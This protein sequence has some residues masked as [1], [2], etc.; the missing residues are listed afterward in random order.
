[1]FIWGEK[2]GLT[3]AQ[4][5]SGPQ[6]KP[7]NFIPLIYDDSTPK[8]I[9]DGDLYKR[10]LKF[11]LTNS[12]DSTSELKL[13]LY[14]ICTVK[15]KQRTLWTRNKILNPYYKDITVD[16]I[17]ENWRSG[18]GTEE[19]CA[20][21]SGSKIGDLKQKVLDGKVCKY[22]NFHCILTLNGNKTIL[23]I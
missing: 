10:Q 23:L 1:M 11:T 22:L 4:S 14:E 7:S 18:I 19:D 16:G 5:H 2:W 12:D 13:K 20:K 8:E 21:A 3:L 17:N 15:D 9:C 6:L